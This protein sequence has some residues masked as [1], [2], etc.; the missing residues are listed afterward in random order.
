MRRFLRGDQDGK[1]T[2]LLTGKHADE[3][4]LLLSVP[5]ARADARCSVIVNIS[6]GDLTNENF[7]ENFREGERTT[8][9]AEPDLFSCADP[10]HW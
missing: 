9:P 3:L 2:F 7:D 4:M 8:E 5:L 10:D 6:P 1:L